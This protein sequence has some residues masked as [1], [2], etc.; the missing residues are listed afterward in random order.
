MCETSTTIP[1]NELPSSRMP[2][3]RTRHVCRIINFRAAVRSQQVRGCAQCNDLPSV[4]GNLCAACD[5][6]SR[7]EPR[8]DE[9]DP[10]GPAF[11][12]LASDI[13]L[14]WKPVNSS[15]KV[16]KIFS[17]VNSQGARDK[18]ETK[19]KKLISAGS[20]QMLRTFHSSQCIC[21]L[22]HLDSKICDTPSCGICSVLKS[23]FKLFAFGIPHNDGRHGKGIYSYQ[24][25]ACADRHSTSCTSSPYRVMIS[26]TV[27]IQDGKS[28][29]PKLRRVTSISDDDGV[30]V[31]DPDAIIARH[32]ILYTK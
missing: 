8:L 18:F 4:E 22:G 27:A 32:V 5:R 16:A 11:K 9:L 15:V 23:S 10:H 2:H 26:C 1:Y 21:N 14:L 13:D 30:F 6:Q 31:S 29:L 25:P 28:W 3:S 24:N 20:V 19:Q 17:I 12:R 7:A